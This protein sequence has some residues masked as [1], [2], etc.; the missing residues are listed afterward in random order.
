VGA[1]LNQQPAVRVVIGPLLPVALVTPE[2][3]NLADVLEGQVE[4]RLPKLLDQLAGVRFIAPGRQ[5]V[6][7]G[8]AHIVPPFM[9]QRPS[10][11]VTH[12]M[13]L[14]VTPTTTTTSR[15]TL[16]AE[17]GARR[18]MWMQLTGRTNGLMLVCR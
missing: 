1:R 17:P 11:S 8:Q 18:A 14:P 4:R 6:M 15:L 7:D 13:P 5:L 9:V 10:Q 12:E 3:D 16:R 2:L